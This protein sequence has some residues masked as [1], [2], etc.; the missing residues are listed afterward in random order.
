MVEIRRDEVSEEAYRVDSLFD[1][2]DV[3]NLRDEAD[4]TT[5]LMIML[6]NNPEYNALAIRHYEL[7]HSSL[8]IKKRDKELLEIESRMSQIEK[9]YVGEFFNGQISNVI[10]PRFESEL[11][12]EDPEVV[13]KEAIK[14]YREEMAVIDNTQL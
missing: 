8:F 3:N 4:K 12:E 2:E 9:E 13:L 11:P 7:T 5:E 6:Y 10:D 1:D 14:K